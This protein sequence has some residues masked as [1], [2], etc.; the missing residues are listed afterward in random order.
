MHVARHDISVDAIEHMLSSRLETLVHE[1]LPNGQRRGHE[2]VALNPGRADTRMGSLSVNLT[3]GRWADFAADKRGSRKFPVLSLVASFATEGRW[4]SEGPTRPGCVRWA[5]D[6]LGLTDRNAPSARVA[7]IEEEAA[8]ALAKRNKELALAVEKKRAGAHAMWLNAKP[9]D[10]HD[11]ASLYLAARGIDIH[12][13]DDIPG[14]LRWAMD[15]RRYTNRG[16]YDEHPAMLAA[17]HREGAPGGFA[18][19]HRTYLAQEGQR[20]WK[21]FGKESKTMLGPKSGATIRLHKG[22]SGKPLARAPEGERVAVAE[23]I[24]NALS[25]AIAMPALRVLA[26]GSLDNIAKIQLPAQIHTVAVCADNDSPGSEPARALDRATDMLAN[27]GYDV[28]ILRA[29]AGFKD[30]NAVLMGERQ[31]T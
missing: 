5:R 2:Y 14:A 22:F 12:A 26:A 7:A 9:L 20:W 15:V 6:W 3:T 4:K 17:M 19:V 31:T 23:G 1:L 21:A 10:G 30:F 29:P 27:R 28:E 25:A 16:E 13:F 11:P 18:A 8:K 24:E